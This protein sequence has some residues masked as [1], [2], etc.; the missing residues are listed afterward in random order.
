MSIE[1]RLCRLLSV[2]RAKGTRNLIGAILTALAAP[3]LA[4]DRVRITL[5]EQEL[6][7]AITNGTPAVWDKYLDPDVIYAEEDVTDR[8]KRAGDDRR[9]GASFR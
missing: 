4:D 8:H 6:S 7:D 2:A 3:A 1:Q 9:N 5:Y